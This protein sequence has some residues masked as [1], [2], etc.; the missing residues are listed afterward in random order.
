MEVR[1]LNFGAKDC[2]E[3][4]ERSGTLPAGASFLEVKNEKKAEGKVRA[5]AG[6]D[7]IHYYRSECV[8][9]NKIVDGCASRGG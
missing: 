6:L 2:S 5:L 7:S 1:E 9:Y 8:F 3:A 4:Q